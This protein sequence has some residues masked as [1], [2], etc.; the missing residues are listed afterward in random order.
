MF[1]SVPFVVQNIHRLTDKSKMCTVQT[2]RAFLV[3]SDKF[4]TGVYCSNFNR[5]TGF[6]I[7]YCVNI[8]LFVTHEQAHWIPIVLFIHVP[9]KL[10][11]LKKN[12]KNNTIISLFEVFHGFL[13]FSGW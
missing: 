11:F 6:L 2:V 3:P 4:V 5:C 8:Q 12:G 10:H 13:F 1:I 9:D 7:V